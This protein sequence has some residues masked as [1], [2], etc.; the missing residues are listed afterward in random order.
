VLR[1]LE[2]FGNPAAWK[3]IQK[4]GM[5]KDHSW[6]ASAREYVKVYRGLMRDPD[7]I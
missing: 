7:G 2:A 6:D 1:A 5:V 4:A 3:R